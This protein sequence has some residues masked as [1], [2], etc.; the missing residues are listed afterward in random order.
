MYV[1]I[2]H[3]IFYMKFLLSFIKMIYW[4]SKEN[5]ENLTFNQLQYC[6]MRNFGGQTDVNKTVRLFLERLSAHVLLTEHSIA[7]VKVRDYS[8]LCN[9]CYYL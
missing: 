2:N 9:L 1:V 7:D 5:G 6:L 8:L 4:I 3:I